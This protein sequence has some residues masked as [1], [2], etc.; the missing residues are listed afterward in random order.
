MVIFDFLLPE[1]LKE[2]FSVG[3]DSYEDEDD[4][5]T[6]GYLNTIFLD[7]VTISPVKS[8]VLSV[9][10]LMVDT[11]LGEICNHQSNIL[12]PVN[13]SIDYIQAATVSSF[14]FCFRNVYE[15]VQIPLREISLFILEDIVVECVTADVSDF[16]PV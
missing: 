9:S 3:V 16:T 10:R 13:C 8:K 14:S 1:K 11:I 4:C 15:A 12:L 5:H 2:A 6:E 7:A